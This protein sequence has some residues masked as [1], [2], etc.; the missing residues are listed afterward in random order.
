MLGTYL[1]ILKE[2]LEKKI[3]ALKSIEEIGNAQS[4]LL[5]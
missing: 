5:R 4:E 3:E 2:S 1:N